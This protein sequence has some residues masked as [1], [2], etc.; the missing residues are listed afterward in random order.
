[1]NR[2]SD[3]EIREI[4]QVQPPEVSHVGRKG[5]GTGRGNSKYIT[6]IIQ[7]CLRLTL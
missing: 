7:L 1:M 3:G 6:K 4:S 2:V 5:R